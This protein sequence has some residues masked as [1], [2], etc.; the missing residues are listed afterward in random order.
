MN[1]VVNAATVN[2][3]IWRK[4]KVGLGDPTLTEQIQIYQ[5]RVL[6]DKLRYPIR[7][8]PRPTK[9][10]I[11]GKQVKEDRFTYPGPA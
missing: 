4:Q 11:V 9:L 6:E 2:A 5:A 7:L 1:R 3:L 10:M 8:P